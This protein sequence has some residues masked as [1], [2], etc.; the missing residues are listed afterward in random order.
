MHIQSNIDK[1]YPQQNV[2]GRIALNKQLGRNT[3]F[4]VIMEVMDGRTNHTAI[5]V[6]DFHG[7]QFKYTV[8][9]LAMN[10]IVRLQPFL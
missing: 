8:H 3:K 4:N 7:C 2:N 6:W 9:R 5:E 10:R 1:F